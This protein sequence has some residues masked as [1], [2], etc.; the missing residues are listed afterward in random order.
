V[1]LTL[2]RP[3][4][5]R[6][7]RR[8]MQPLQRVISGTQPSGRASSRSDIR[9]RPCLRLQEGRTVSVVVVRVDDAWLSDVE[10]RSSTCKGACQLR[11]RKQGLRFIAHLR[12]CVVLRRWDP[13]QTP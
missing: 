4:I 6:Y 9:C 3:K 8:Y 10:L 2:V 12:S 11:P 1:H 13:L 7:D 5:R